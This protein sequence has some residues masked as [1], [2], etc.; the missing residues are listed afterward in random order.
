MLFRWT[1]GHTV[2]MPFGQVPH[3]LTHKNLRPCAVDLS[4]KEVLMYLEHNSVGRLYRY[5]KKLESA[6]AKG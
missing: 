4:P 3:G 2:K 1:N 6:L 5:L